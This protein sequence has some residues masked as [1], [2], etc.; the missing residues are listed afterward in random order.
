MGKKQ[1]NKKVA[2]QVIVRI[3]TI[4]DI[5]NIRDPRQEIDGVIK[6]ANKRDSVGKVDGE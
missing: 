1:D 5:N 2:N 4:Q 3:S 6:W